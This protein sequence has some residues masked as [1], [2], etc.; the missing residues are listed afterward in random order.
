MD[1]IFK[2]ILDKFSF[3]VETEI[4]DDIKP[5]YIYVKPAIVISES[6][7]QDRDEFTKHSRLYTAMQLF[8]NH[9]LSSGQAAELA[10]IDKF[11]FWAELI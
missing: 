8:K 7:N 1:L 9:K 3:N 6:L 4:E 5:G 11:Q 2:R 10:R